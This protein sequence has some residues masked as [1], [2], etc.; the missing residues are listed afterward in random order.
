MKVA[1]IAAKYDNPI[2][3]PEK[4]FKILPK[5]VCLFTTIQFMHQLE[6]IKQQLENKGI[7]V[8]LRESTNYYYQGKKTREGQLLGCNLEEFD[9]IDAFLY[10]GDGL[11]HPKIL[12]VKNNQSV[13]GYDPIAEVVEKLDSK[14]IEKLKKK[15]QGAYAKFLSSKEIG[16]LISTK[17][18]QNYLNKAEKLREKFP[19]KNF[20]FILFNDINFTE[21]ENFNFVECWINTACYR[22]GYDDTNKMTKAVINILDIPDFL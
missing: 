2:L 22:I 10:I 8:T 11:F 6:S 15:Q 18:G 20:Y 14:D 7:T 17:P 19:E 13:Y 1:F 16:V 3:L 12:M 4:L 21:L 9:N 5:K